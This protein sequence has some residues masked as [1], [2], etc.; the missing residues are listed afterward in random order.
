MGYNKFL[1]L[2]YVCKC[3]CCSAYLYRVYTWS[4]QWRLSIFTHFPRPNDR[5]LHVI[6]IEIKSEGLAKLP[7]LARP[8]CR[9]SVI[10]THQV[11]WTPPA[12]KCS[13]TSENNRQ[14][15]L[16]ECSMVARGPRGGTEMLR[17]LFNI[18]QYR[19]SIIFQSK[20]SHLSMPVLH[21]DIMVYTLSPQS[22]TVINVHDTL[23]DFDK[24]PMSPCCVW[25][26]RASMGHL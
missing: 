22:S 24:I 25:G 8:L 16:S 20:V 4:F 21:F 17:V 23:F 1:N 15:G 13:V 10:I 11:E 7:C 26:S 2:D 9:I 5:V 6:S 18:C 3:V 19:I 12:G 14:Y